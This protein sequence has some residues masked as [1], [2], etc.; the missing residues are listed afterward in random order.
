MLTDRSGRARRRP[1][2]RAV[3]DRRGRVGTDRRLFG[4]PGV[5]VYTTAARDVGPRAECV[6]GIVSLS[7]V[8]ADLGRRGIQSVLIE[9]G[10]DMAASALESGIVDKIVVFVAPKIFGGREVPVVG[11]PGIR[12]LDEAIALDPWTVER[13]GP[14]LVINAYVHRDH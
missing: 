12:T 5:L 1:L 11:G 8:F 14:D 10:P 2:V 6:S 4:E 9:C 3:M 7:E 13:V